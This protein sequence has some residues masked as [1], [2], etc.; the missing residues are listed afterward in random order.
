MTVQCFSTKKCPKKWMK[1]NANETL[2]GHKIAQLA[3]KTSPLNFL[4]PYFRAFFL[5]TLNC[6]NSKTVRA[7]D[8]IPTLRAGH[9]YQLS[10]DMH[11]AKL[12]RLDAAKSW[13]GSLRKFQKQPLGPD[14]EES[15]F[16]KP[17]NKCFICQ[18]LRS[19]LKVPGHQS[20]HRPL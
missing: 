19:Y 1:W 13:F 8:L 17:K 16:I 14:W 6:H 12:M 3:Q 10:S 20:S 9:K 11:T 7:L 15:C 4:N 18:W 5:T 2:K